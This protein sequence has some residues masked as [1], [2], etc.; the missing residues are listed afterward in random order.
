MMGR[1][2]WSKYWAAGVM[3]LA[4]AVGC[5][6]DKNQN[7][8]L[9]LIRPSLDHLPYQLAR[10]ADHPDLAG[11]EI[12]YFTSGWETSEALAAGRL[13]AA[14]LPFTYAW[15]AVSRGLPVRIVSFLERESDGIVARRN[16]GSLDDLDGKRIGVLRASTIEI[17]AVM[18]LDD[19]GLSAEL[20]P[21]RGP[22]EMVAALRA[23]DVDALSFYVPPILTLGEQFHV[24]YW[25]GEDHPGHPCCDLV[26]YAP[27]ARKKEAALSR[28]RQALAAATAQVETED[29]QAGAAAAAVDL[30]NLPPHVA[31]AALARLRFGMGREASGREFQLRAASVM[32]DLGYLDVVPDTSDVYLP[33]ARR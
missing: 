3:V 5:S 11:I 2:H 25:Y 9:G 30:Y 33:L 8:V 29:W 19:R 21:L 22:A 24:V 26:V 13:D 4:F 17:L 18:A 20:V 27:A 7:L 31:D 32:R 15:T 16:I 10:L 23:G 14:I 28:L 12:R 6:G 1:G